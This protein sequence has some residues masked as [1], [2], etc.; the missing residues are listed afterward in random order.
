MLTQEKFVP[1]STFWTCVHLLIY[2]LSTPHASPDQKL[3]LSVSTLFTVVQKNV[4]KPHQGINLF[5][6]LW[7]F[8]FQTPF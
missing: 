4:L 6:I 1:G 2:H 7:I 8:I 3:T 5:C